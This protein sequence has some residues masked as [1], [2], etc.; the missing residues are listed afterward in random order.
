MYIAQLVFQPLSSFVLV[1]FP[2][3]YWVLLCMFGC[4][5][6]SLSTE[7]RKAV[8]D[9]RICGTGSVVTTAMAAANSF[10]G[11]AT[12]SFLLGMFQASIANSC[13]AITQRWWRRREQVSPLLDVC[14]SPGLIGGC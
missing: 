6:L 14:C 1:R 2:I 10:A 3:K 4:K 5:F 8:S 7:G 13:V 9:V 11:L 12:A